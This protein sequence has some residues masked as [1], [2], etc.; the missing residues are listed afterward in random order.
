MDSPVRISNEH[1][2]LLVWIFH[3]LRQT[4]SGPVLFSWKIFLPPVRRLC[5]L[6]VC[7]FVCLQ[8]YAKL[9]NRFAQ[10]GTWAT[11]EPVRFWM[12][13]G[14][15]YIGLGLWL[16][17]MFHV[18]SSQPA[19]PRPNHNWHWHGHWDHN[20]MDCVTVRWGPNHNGHWDHNTMDCVTVRWRPNHNG[21]WD[22]NTMDCVTV[23]WRPNHNGHWTTGLV[24]PDIVKGTVEP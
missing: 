16:Q 2:V 12:L 17:L 24:L 9:L 4:N 11:E 1:G 20:T 8:D 6:F 14:S 18:T 23:R 3:P 7:L 5:L 22:H 10:N 19:G 13:S 15:L 21:D